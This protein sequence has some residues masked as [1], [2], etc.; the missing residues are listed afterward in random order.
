MKQITIF[1]SFFNSYP[2]TSGA[3]AVTTS[4]FNAWHGSKKLFQINDKKIKNKNLY[5]FHNY[6]KNKFFK[7]FLFFFYTVFIIRKIYKYK[8]NIKY[9][10][11]EGASWTGYVYI[12]F[13]ILNKIFT[14]TKFIYHSHNI[15]FL[16]RNK[17]IIIRNISYFFEKK[18]LTKFN[19]ATAVSSNDQKKFKHHFNAKTIILPNFIEIKKKF[20]RKIKLK[21]Y[22]FFAGSLEFFENKKIFYL[23]LKNEFRIIKKYFPNVKIFHSGGGNTRTFKN[24]KDIIELG[25]LKRNQYLKY[26]QKA[27]LVVVPGSGGPGTKIKI[28]ESLSYNKTTLASCA[29]TKGIVDSFKKDYT[30][31]NL[32][33]FE[34]KLISVKNNKVKKYILIG[35]FF[36]NKYNIKNILRN[37]Y[38][39]IKSL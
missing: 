18:I 32:R 27:F 20:L 1:I 38:A 8:N 35:K 11:F 13:I 26:L 33:E 24:N 9:I 16:I 21:N 6:T 39:E 37:F 31:K 4:L 15:D 12:S 17:N 25:T 7:F 14:N 30:Y 2:I 29:S 28:I 23:L 10:I 34:N 22:V 36:R 3:S 19:L 5:T